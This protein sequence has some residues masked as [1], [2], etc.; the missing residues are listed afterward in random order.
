MV[1]G[2]LIRGMLVGLPPAS[3]RSSS[4]RSSASRRSTRRSPSRR[5]RA[6]RGRGAAVSP[7]HAVDARP[8]DRHGRLGAAL[9][10]IFAL[11]FAAAYGRIG[12][13]T[14]GAPP[15]S[16]ARRLRDDLPGAVHEVPVEPARRRQRG[17]DRLPHDDLLR[18]D[19]D[20]GL[21]RDRRAAPRRRAFAAARRLERALAAVGAFIALI[22]LG[23]L[24]LPALDETPKDF[25]ADVIWHFRVATLGIHPVIWTTLGLGFGA[26]A[27]RLLSPSRT[28]DRAV[29]SAPAS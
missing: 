23:E 10:G 7:R 2:L 12:K 14:R 3:S 1:R 26:A 22:A 25:P 11:V 21:R 17:H 20:L 24:M 16:C 28:P 6:R 5:P 27:Q 15:R 8:A 18:D 13:P 29:A 4:P 9:G 19:R